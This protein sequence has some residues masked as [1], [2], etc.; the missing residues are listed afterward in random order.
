MLTI[1]AVSYQNWM[2][3][4]WL[5]ISTCKPSNW[6]CRWPSE[7][8]PMQFATS[9]AVVS[10]YKL[11]SPS[12]RHNSRKYQRT[13]RWYGQKTRYNSKGTRWI[14]AWFIAKM[15][16]WLMFENKVAPLPASAGIIPRTIG[17]IRTKVAYT[18]RRILNIAFVLHKFNHNHYVNVHYPICPPRSMAGLSLCR[19]CV[20][21]IDIPMMLLASNA[22]CPNSSPVGSLS[23]VKLKRTGLAHWSK[24]P[25]L[26]MT[27][28]VRYR[29]TTWCTMYISKERIVGSSPLVLEHCLYLK[30]WLTCKTI[31]VWS[32]ILKLLIFSSRSQWQSPCSM[33][34][35]SKSLKILPILLKLHLALEELTLDPP[36]TTPTLATNSCHFQLDHFVCS[37]HCKIYLCWI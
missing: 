1:I 37:L 31:P 33:H 32:I 2:L 12:S 34:M 8:L 24:L 9:I 28:E 20:P 15:C 26:L 29:C 36:R 6:T 11:L 35:I 23:F 14:V 21:I 19:R 5:L 25:I 18:Y 10:S 13:G 27:R 17:S 4:D 22:S 7:C 30:M 3:D 16:W